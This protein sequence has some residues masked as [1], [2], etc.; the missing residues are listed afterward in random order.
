MKIKRE[1]NEKGKIILNFIVKNPIKKDPDPRQN[2]NK[3]TDPHHCAQLRGGGGG[4]GGA[5][6]GGARVLHPPQS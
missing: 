2:K 4:D 1:K 6:W 3:K 5:A